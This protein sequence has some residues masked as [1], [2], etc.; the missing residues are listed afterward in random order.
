MGGRSFFT[1]FTDLQHTVILSINERSSAC[2]YLCYYEIVTCGYSTFFLFGSSL[3]SIFSWLKIVAISFRFKQ[4]YL[5]V[6]ESN[7]P[8]L[9][10]IFS[11]DEP[12]GDFPDIY[13]LKS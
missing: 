9:I 2:F 11:I 6:Q 1:T 5:L 8:N 13:S 3:N 7:I 4:I 10:E 12:A